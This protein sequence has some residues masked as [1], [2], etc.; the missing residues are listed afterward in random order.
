MQKLAASL[1]ASVC[2]L[3]TMHLRLF[4]FNELIA[5]AVFHGILALVETLGCF[6]DH[7]REVVAP[8]RLAFLPEGD[9]HPL[10]RAA[11]VGVGLFGVLPSAGIELSQILL[12]AGLSLFFAFR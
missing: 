5:R 2:V 6:N 10:W 7:R 12:G 1:V 8:A 3:L 4:D 11:S 9:A